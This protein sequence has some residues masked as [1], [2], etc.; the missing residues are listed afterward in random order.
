MRRMSV[1]PDAAFLGQEAELPFSPLSGSA[2]RDRQARLETTGKRGCVSVAAER[3]W[4]ASSRFPSKVGGGSSQSGT[5]RRPADS[6]VV[7]CRGR[8]EA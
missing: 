4:P 5:C 8:C 7:S 2:S 3:L 1:H 6:G